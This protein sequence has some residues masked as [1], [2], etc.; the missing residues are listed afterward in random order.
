MTVTLITENYHFFPVFVC[1]NVFFHYF[2]SMIEQNDLFFTDG[3][4]NDADSSD[5]RTLMCL[6]VKERN[7]VMTKQLSIINRVEELRCVTQFVDDIAK[8]LNLNEEMHMN[9]GLVLEEMVSNVIFYAYPK[10]IVGTINLCAKS[11][12]QSLTLLLSDKGYAFDPTQIE[13]NDMEANPA[14]RPIGGM[15]IYIVKNIMNHVSYQRLDGRNL[16]TMSII[17][18]ERVSSMT[19]ILQQDGQTIIKTVARIDTLNAPQFEKDIEPALAEPGVDLV[20]D[21][22]ELT[23][24]A[25]SGLRIIQK[26]MRSVT[27][28]KGNFKIINVSPSVYKVL[29]MTGFTKFMTIEQKA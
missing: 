12:G 29:K 21:C 22:Q 4:R 10:D 7:D 5:N 18:N 25:S 23:F 20:M 19:Q 14:E 1:L 15:G 8:E 26:T 27:T 9:I 13:S 6:S 3:L 28:G 16:L 24:I 2:C 11:D 17:I